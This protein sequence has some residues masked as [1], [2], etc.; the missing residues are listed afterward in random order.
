MDAPRTLAIVRILSVVDTRDYHEVDERW[1][2]IPGSGTTATCER[3]GRGHEIHASVE[4]ADGT[5]AAVGTGCM[6][7]DSLLKE[8]RAAASAAGTI[9]KLEATR[10]KL[11]RDAA[12]YVRITAEV[13][14]LTSPGAVQGTTSQGFDAVFIGDACMHL[15][16]RSVLEATEL[17]VRV[18]R[19]NRAKE[20]GRPEHAS[21]AMVQCEVQ[22]LDRR[23]V[24]ARAKLTVA[25]SGAA[26]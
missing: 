26:A 12:E 1:V 18:W 17:A 8:A 10:A 3:C 6:D 14:A 15:T 23:I 11:V 4:L 2:P 7:N 19:R 20:R 13:E 21:P 22:A 24:K 5:V 16:H 9:R 25:P